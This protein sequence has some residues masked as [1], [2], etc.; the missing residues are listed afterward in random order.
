MNNNSVQIPLNIGAEGGD[1]P[2]PRAMETNEQPAAPAPN[3]PEL[4]PISG[5]ESPSPSPPPVVYFFR[6]FPYAFGN[7][8]L[9]RHS[10][11]GIILHL[12]FTGQTV[13]YANSNRR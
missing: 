6:F 12:I 9:R 7:R 10:P 2:S 3:A 4:E 11:V 13:P 8:G 5:D 1:H